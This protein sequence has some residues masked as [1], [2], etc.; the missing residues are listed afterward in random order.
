MRT[1][2]CL[3]LILLSSADAQAVGKKRPTPVV[4]PPK[5]E[6]LEYRYD[7]T[8]DECLDA[9]GHRGRNNDC[10][11]RGL[12][13]ECGSGLYFNDDR[14][15]VDLKL[16]GLND[17][18]LEAKGGLVRRAS[19]RGAKF[20]YATLENIS[21]DGCDLTNARLTGAKKLAEV[22]FLDTKLD[23][24][25]I[26]GYGFSKI[27][28]RNVSF[29]NGQL[30]ASTYEGGLLSGALQE[31][32]L[33]SSVVTGDFS[34]SHFEGVN[35]TRAR[36][37]GSGF[38]RATFKKVDFTEAA[39]GGNM[40]GID[41]SSAILSRARL[42]GDARE[43]KLVGA[44]LDE[45]QLR[46]LDLRAAFLDRADLS[47][48]EVEVYG[49][50]TRQTS[51]DFARASFKGARLNRLKAEYGNFTGADLS[52]ASAVSAQFPKATFAQ[53]RL[54]GA[55]LSG[56]NLREARLTSASLRGVNLRNADLTRAAIF[57]A[58]LAGAMYDATTLLPMSDHDAYLL[59]MKKDGGFPWESR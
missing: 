25:S 56:A 9:Q 35:F 45:A 42:T 3:L 48:A 2:A 39:L 40:I 59:G 29:R 27:K 11:G 22:W 33:T 7:E 18:Y 23:G 46:N 55:D 13:C 20:E 8:R 19:L 15:I 54:D 44:R 52:G 1:L 51:V 49:H 47:D 12:N 4:V 32:D 38:G 17:N 58:D 37:S 24:A 26:T 57:G 16:D 41:L 5:I 21:F 43:A 34:G 36:V 31:V 14:R 6:P 30:D 50:S 53:A 10:R 28:L